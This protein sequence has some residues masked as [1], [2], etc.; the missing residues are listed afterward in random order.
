MSTQAPTENES[1]PS[2]AVGLTPELQARLVKKAAKTRFAGRATYWLGESIYGV[3]E[4]ENLGHGDVRLKLDRFL[5]PGEEVQLQ[6]D[7]LT[8]RGAPVHLNTEVISCR[9]SY[10]ERCFIVLLQILA[11]SEVLR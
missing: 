9:R 6:L 7:C 8:Y 4:A 3:A 11:K 5:A 10:S 2:E 1:P